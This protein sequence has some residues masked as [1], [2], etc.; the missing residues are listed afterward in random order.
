MFL[1]NTSRTVAFA[2]LKS[3]VYLDLGDGTVLLV[4]LGHMCTSSW[5]QNGDFYDLV[6]IQSIVR[7][8]VHTTTSFDILITCFQDALRSAKYAVT[9]VKIL[10]THEFGNDLL[11]IVSKS[12]KETNQ[13]E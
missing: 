2:R 13:N 8:Y 4:S 12:I 5:K 1:F 9:H 3:G 7:Q 6:Q 11:M 10:G